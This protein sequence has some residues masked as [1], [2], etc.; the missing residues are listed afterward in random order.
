MAAT[1]TRG[2]SDG[3]SAIVRALQL[4]GLRP[5]RWSNGP[6]ETY[7]AH[8]HAYHKVLYCLAGSI[9]F[10][11]DDGTEIEL[12]PGDRL[13][14]EPQTRHSAVVGSRGVTCVEAPRA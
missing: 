3:E 4:D 6:G 10:R 11:L 5:Q 1:V 12:Q 8:E 2:G 7:A 14:I 9:T 13:E